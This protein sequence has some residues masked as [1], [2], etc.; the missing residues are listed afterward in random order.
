MK[1][2]VDTPIWSLAFRKKKDNVNFKTIENLVKLI[3]SGS[4]SIIGPIRQEVLSGISDRHKFIDIKEKMSVFSDYD[5][6][7]SDFEF[8]AE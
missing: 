5:L 2:L 4:I 1:V 8:A 3:H 6:Q 7:S